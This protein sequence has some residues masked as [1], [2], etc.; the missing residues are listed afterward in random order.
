MKTILALF[1]AL[2]VAF[3]AS[4]QE[5]NPAD[6][7]VVLVPVFF[8]G[9]GAHGSS[10]TTDVEMIDTSGAPITLAHA[11][12]MGDPICPSACGCAAESEVPEYQTKR[13]CLAFS[14]PGGLLLHVPKGTSLEDLQIMARARDLS[15][16]EDSA[17]TQIPVVPRSAFL[18]SPE[19]ILL[20]D[21]PVDSR[22][23]TSLRIFDLHFYRPEALIRVYDAASLIAGITAPI[24]DETLQFEES[25]PGDLRPIPD[26]PR[27]YISIGDLVARFPVLA[28]SSRIAIEIHVAHSIADPPQPDEAYW[29]MASVTNNATQ[30]VTIIAPD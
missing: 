23:R 17:G 6:Y 8:A 27:W 14:N 11:L 4:A 15:R 16:E 20:H 7:D 29:A 30:Q 12:L 18:E 13:A 21:V 28:G 19:P 3:A 22:F 25:V 1:F 24:V 5:P 9:P 2:L 26:H 10:W